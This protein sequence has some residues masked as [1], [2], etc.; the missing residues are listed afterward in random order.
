MFVEQLIVHHRSLAIYFIADLRQQLVEV[1]MRCHFLFLATKHPDNTILIGEEI[2][3]NSLIEQSLFILF[4][5][6]NLIHSHPV[7]LI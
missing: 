6:L 7:V 4:Q 5:L 3:A 1:T 2:I